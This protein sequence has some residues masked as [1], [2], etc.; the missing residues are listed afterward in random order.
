MPAA[1]DEDSAK[2]EN[3]LKIKVNLPLKALN[4]KE[5]QNYHKKR[6]SVKMLDSIGVRRWDMTCKHFLELS[7]SIQGHNTA[8]ARIDQGSSERTRNLAE[9][10]AEQKRRQRA[11]FRAVQRQKRLPTADDAQNELLVEQYTP[12]NALKETDREN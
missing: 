2:V 4:S 12:R 8:R 6:F 10:C 5:A 7:K 3:P 11:H 1:G 9:T